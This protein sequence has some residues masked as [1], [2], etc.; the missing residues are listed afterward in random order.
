MFYKKF[1][2]TRTGLRLYT[3]TIG[4][5]VR[6]GPRFIAY[7]FLG[8]FEWFPG[9]GRSANFPWSRFR[10]ASVVRDRRGGGGGGGGVYGVYLAV[11]SSARCCS[12]TASR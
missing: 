6:S 7:P 11:A 2:K 1:T 10:L 5:L 9:F 4:P 3:L 12:C 8:V